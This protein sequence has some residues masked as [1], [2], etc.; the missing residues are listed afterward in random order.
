MNRQ[1]DKKNI[2]LS[3]RIDENLNTK[4]ESLSEKANRSKSNFVITLLTKAIDDIERNNNLM[5]S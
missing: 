3:F 4:I 1:K 5:N 2:T